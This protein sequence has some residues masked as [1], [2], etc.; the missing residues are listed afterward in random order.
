MNANNLNQTNDEL[1]ARL[2]DQ[3]ES[4]SPDE[5]S[6]ILADEECRQLY[7]AALETRA[8]MQE[9][10]IGREET[11]AALRKLKSHRTDHRMRWRLA[12]AVAGVVLLGGISYATLSNTGLLSGSAPASHSTGAAVTAQA[13]AAGQQQAAQPADGTPAAQASAA[14][15]QDTITFTNAP[16]S[17]IVG[18]VAARH[19]LTADVRNATAGALRIYY[20]WVVADNVEKVVDDLN[21]FENVKITI[22]DAKLIID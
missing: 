7:D 22:T 18:Q 9:R 2:I 4:L 3:P 19:G 15:A 6:Q 8:L 20:V 10:Q 17:T 5:I 12:A 16:L 11:A 21:T 14:Q 13:P 1:V